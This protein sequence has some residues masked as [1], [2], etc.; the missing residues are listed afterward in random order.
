MTNMD[1]STPPS[2]I[3]I[4]GAGVFGL[5]TALELA[6]RPNFAQTKITV[7]D[8]SP[9]QG[10][11]PSPDASSVDTSRIIRP[12]Y[13]DRAYATL[14]AEAH[15]E[16]RKTGDD[17]LGGQGR[18]S[19]SGLMLIADE[20]PAEVLCQAPGSGEKKCSGMDYVRQSWDNV[21]DLAREGGGMSTDRMRELPN[22]DAINEAIGMGKEETPGDWGYLN[23][24]SGWADAE[25]SMHW[26]FRRV[27]ATGRVAF[28]HGTATSLTRSG[29]SVTGALLEDGRELTADLVLVATGAWT[30]ALVDL[31][32]QAVATGQAVAFMDI[33]PEE[34]AALAGMPVILNFSTGLFVI[35][36]SR[37]QLKAARHAYGYVNPVPTPSTALPT[38]PTARRPARMTSLPRTH[39]TDPKLWIP[40]EGEEDLRRIIRRIIPLKQLHDRPFVSSR[41]C[42]YTDTNSGDFII[43]YHPGWKGLFVA[44]AGSGHGFKFLPIIGKKITDCIEGKRPPEF[45]T[46]W[47]WRGAEAPETDDVE[48][49]YKHIVTEDGSRGGRPG[50][51]L[52]DELARSTTGKLKL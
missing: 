43:D 50:M 29:D 27:R 41:L 37:G 25:K 40:A 6:R 24:N 30:G 23:G 18:Y 5:S 34:E 8:R 4:I 31:A 39:I 48:E 12:D 11:F 15:E 36:P 1:P 51:V 44:T 38:T 14:A 33:T 13:C 10:V 42:W 17:D 47:K 32:G 46:K 21:L 7:L 49:L 3:L 35:P 2:S 52:A 45:D 28:I 19:E 22:R 20:P 26:L 9:E 16:W